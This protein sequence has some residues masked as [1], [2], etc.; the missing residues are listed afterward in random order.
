[1]ASLK[2]AFV[3]LSVMCMLSGVLF[4]FDLSPYFYAS[5]KNVTVSYAN[6]TLGG[7]NYS[8]VKFNGVDTFLLMN[9]E[10][11]RN[12]SDIEPVLQ[13]YYTQ[14]YYPTEDELGNLT[15][16]VKKFNDSRNDGYD[17]KNKEEY[18]CR[19]DVLLS[20][21]KIK[22]GN[23]SMVCRDNASCTKIALLLYAAYGEGLNLGTASVLVQPLMDFTISILEMDDI[24][25]NYSARL[26]NMSQDTVSETMDYIK[27]TAPTLKAD[28]LKIEATI[29]RT[30][31]L[32]DT[33]DRKACQFKCYAICPSFDLDQQTADDLKAMA[34]TLGDKVAPLKNYQSI[35]ATLAS[36]SAARLNYAKVEST[37]DYY[38]DLFR[39]L[40][41]S[42][43]E[44]IALGK[45]AKKRVTNMTLNANLDKLMALHATIP[46]DIA[47]RNFT[48]LEVDLD[49]YRIYAGTTKN[50]SLSVLGKYNQTLEAKNTADSLMLVLETKDLDASALETFNV[51]KN[52]TADLDAAFRDGYT[53]SQL[54]AMRLN[55]TSVTEDAQELLKSESDVP[56]SKAVLLFRG[57]AR[58][59]NGGIAKFAVA[60]QLSDAQGIMDNRLL[61]FGGFSGLVFLSLTALSLLFFLYI[62]V[63]V[64][65]DIPQSRYILGAAFI[66]SVVMFLGFSV[67]LY[68]FLDKTSSSATFT[69]FMSDFSSRN[70][71]SIVL[72][73]RSV[74]YSDAQSMVSCS[75]S[76]SGLFSQENRTWTMYALT[77]NS[78]TESNSLGG[79]STLTVDECLGRAD[80]QSSAFFLGYSPQN[81][82]P[83]F[84]IIYQSKAEIKANSDYYKS[85]PLVA[86]FG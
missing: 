25:S 32:N 20:N 42:G 49:N 16:L 30:P 10:P 1:M 61:S 50:I 28:S 14:M 76:L 58:R 72:D 86:L 40:N 62:L 80:N 48:N 38:S 68:L 77:P 56:A 57:F 36:N 65:L 11:L 7:D 46:D 73:L 81:E 33:V 70:S 75:K 19:N 59:V 71:T 45:D 13:S 47:D 5:E 84:S 3:I 54:E 24:L 4:A 22:V 82:P 29:F 27:N 79:N 18:I 52:R 26:G 53:V 60:T 55:Y 23:T 41:A 64:S 34:T 69:E 78:C 66:C 9:D 15:A 43:N 8:I 37:A 51:L 74:S 21:G 83:K 6:F 44:A 67:F 35:S 63:S 17:F 2:N 31:R 39:E 85:C 12:Q